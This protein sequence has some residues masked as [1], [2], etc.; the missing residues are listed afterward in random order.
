M[1]RFLRGARPRRRQPR[2]GG[3]LGVTESASGGSEPAGGVLGAIEAIGQGT[4][5]FTGFPVSVGIALG[6]ALVVLGL[7]LVRR[8]RATV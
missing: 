5:P 8:G 6:L 1:R 3:V 4:L 7:A 2:Q